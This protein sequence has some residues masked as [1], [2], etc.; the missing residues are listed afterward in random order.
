MTHYVYWLRGKEFVDMA[1]LSMKSVRRIDPK[2]KF[3]VYTD[4]PANT[5]RMG[6]RDVAWY[7]LPAG[8]PPMVANLD[9]QIAALNH[10]IQGEQVLF[11]DADIIMRKPFPF[12]L[13]PHIYV[14]YRNEVK[15]LEGGEVKEADPDMVML[16]PYNYGVLGCHVRPEVIEAFYWLRARVLAMNARNQMWFGN[17][18]ALAELVGVAPKGGDEFDKS[19]RIRWAPLDNGTEL[20]VRQLPCTMWNYSPNS[21]DEDVSLRGILHLKG[22]RKDLMKHYAEAA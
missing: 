21:K 12:T 1:R 18:L 9:A 6:E 2:A 20:N 22:E 14:T 11:L 8:R 10:L 17:Q 5:P 3:D 4:D 13:L 16:Q 19:V 7:E 15:Y